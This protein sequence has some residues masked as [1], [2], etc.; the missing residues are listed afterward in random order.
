[1][2]L[3]SKFLLAD[4]EVYA[5]QLLDKESAVFT[6]TGVM[7]NAIGL[8]GHGLRPDGPRAVMMDERAHVVLREMPL[9]SPIAFIEPT[10]TNAP[11]GPDGEAVENWLRELPSP[12]EAVIVLE[13]TN[14]IRGG[15][16]VPLD[17]MLDVYE[18]AS[19]LGA[20]VH[21]DGTRLFNA[22]I[23]M[24]AGI[25]DLAAASDTVMISLCKGLGAPIGAILAGPD[26]VIK[27]ARTFRTTLGGTMRQSGH[28]AAAGLV[29]LK[30]GWTHMHDDHRRAREL[31][32]GLAQFIHSLDTDAVETNIVLFNTMPLGVDAETFA[33]HAREAGVEM[34]WMAPDTARLVVH[35][36]IS[37]A[38]IAAAVSILS[39]VASEIAQA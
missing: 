39:D 19:R 6:P 32:T 17:R 8:L 11:L 1:M 30:G 2:S 25:A 29:A 5:A 35:R 4:L 10:L 22:A 34:S 37:D 21:L 26:T 3:K 20:R 36:D 13:N 12:E 28:M 14:T 23:A 38:D 15:K 7:A 33:A 24:D 16:I 31:A 18:V 27:K 9:L